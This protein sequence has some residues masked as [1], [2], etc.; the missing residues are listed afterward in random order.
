[1]ADENGNGAAGSTPPSGNT[2]GQSN[3]ASN[4]DVVSIPRQ[5]YDK[6]ARYGDQVKGFQPF[7]QK[8]TAYGFK[9]AEDFDRFDPWLKQIQ[10]LE[11]RGVKAD[12]L[13]RMFNDEADSD[14]NE[15]KDQPAF[16]REAFKK[17][18]EAFKKEIMSEYRKEAAM[19]EF[20]NLTAK[21]KDYAENALKDIYGEDEVDDWTKE[22]RRLAIERYMDSKRDVYPENHPL[23]KDVYLQPLS[24]KQMKD[25]VEYFKKRTDEAKGQTMKQRADAA[26]A[27][28]KKPP[29]A[30]G[31]GAG[32]GKP[33]NESSN[34]S[35][36]DEID[37]LV[38]KAMS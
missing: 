1:M 36:R 30:A 33:K 14:L 26:I 16:D 8:A 23:H 35:P 21:E 37:D 7:H 3:P 6:L 19:T 32:Q 17:E 15:E 34:K 2:G 11:K 28:K 22:Q 24:E 29:T 20:K 10:T 9:S 5:E 25:A 13:A 12:M 27:A 31:N 4:A 38:E 18:R